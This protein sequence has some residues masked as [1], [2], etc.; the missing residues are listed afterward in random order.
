[1]ESED[2]GAVP[3]VEND[4]LAGM[5]TDRDIVIRAIAKG[6]D[7]R[8][9]PVRE[10]YTKQ[11]L[12]VRPE[13]DLKDVVKAMAGYQVRRLAVVDADNHLVGVVSQADVALEAR[14][15]DVGEMVEEISKPPE[16]PRQA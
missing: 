15:K 11:V 4:Q 9:M 1:M 13:D 14:E 10:I 3:V 6:K 7:P 2:V 16:G 8:G 12:A 5:I